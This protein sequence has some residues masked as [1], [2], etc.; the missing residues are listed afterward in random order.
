MTTAVAPLDAASLAA[1]VLEAAK[2][3]DV[4]AAAVEADARADGQVE[5]VVQLQQA[6]RRV[7]GA[8]QE[9]FDVIDSRLAGAEIALA[10]AVEDAG[11]ALL[12]SGQA[13]EEVLRLAANGSATAGRLQDLVELIH[14]LE[15]RVAA[16]ERAPALDDEEYVE[17]EDRFRGP[18]E[19]VRDRQAAYVQ[20]FE[21][22]ERV[23]DVG[24]G[25]GEF[26]DL[27]GRAGIAASGVDVSP[28]MV[29]RG[30]ARGL[31]V[32]RADMFDHLRSLPPGAVDGVFTAQVIEHLPAAK[33]RALF[34]ELGRVLSPGAPLVVETVNPH[35]PGALAQ[36]HLDPTH[37]LPLPPGLVGFLLERTGFRVERL[38]CSA[39]V[40]AGLPE[41]VELPL[42]DS[43]VPVP[44][45]AERYADYALIARRYPSDARAPA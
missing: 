38:R 37:V 22:C 12:R 16:I 28:R 1:R 39:P 9:A 40:L 27:L 8:V 41:A 34:A 26:L 30:V 29:E 4:T 11:A 42:V 36:F 14:R 45:E 31:R 15:G 13:N 19:I 32:V 5:P 35:C 21:G 44:E 2:A 6:L 24:A 25:R 7:L 23:L 43:R 20:I 10:D 33:V 3:R 17:F 18:Y